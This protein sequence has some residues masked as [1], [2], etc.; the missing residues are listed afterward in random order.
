MRVADTFTWCAQ[1]SRR[2]VTVNRRL[3]AQVPAMTS[4]W[5]TIVID[6]HDPGALARFW[7]DA[8]G[9]RVMYEDDEEVL[10]A[11]GDT[12]YPGVCFVPVDDEKTQKNRLHIDLNPEDQYAEVNRLL[13]LGARRVNIGQGNVSWVVLADPEGN[14]FCVLRTHETLTN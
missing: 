8:L 7:A 14:E 10:I 6:A 3:K 5:Y 4:Q 12:D 2:R 11:Q 9:Y 13:A 1:V